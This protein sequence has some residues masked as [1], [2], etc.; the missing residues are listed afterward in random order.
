MKEKRNS[1]QVLHLFSINSSAK[2]EK[3]QLPTP[4]YI[5]KSIF[6]AKATVLLTTFDDP[7]VLLFIVSRKGGGIKEMLSIRS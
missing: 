2:I 7:Y 3:K 5:S 4:Y 1:T 6:L